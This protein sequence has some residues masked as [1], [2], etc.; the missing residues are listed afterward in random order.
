ML[1]ILKEIVPECDPKSFLLDYEVAMINSVKATFPNCT[2]SGCFYHLCRCV[3]RHVASVGLRKEYN[4]N[5]DFCIKVKSLMALAF[6]PPTD[7][8]TVFGQLCAEFPDTDACDKLLKYFKQT[9]IQQTGRNDRPQDPL[10]KIELW[11]HYQDGLNCVPK[12]TNCTGMLEMM[13]FRQYET[14]FH[15]DC[16]NIFS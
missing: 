13:T 8:L 6:V 1:K 14:K 4:S 15:T 12:T 3:T 11:N 9:F 16:F 5:I 2:I 7:V 10:F